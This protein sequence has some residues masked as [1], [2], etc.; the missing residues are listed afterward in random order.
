MN[1]V[2]KIDVKI[3][4]EIVKH[5]LI[6]PTLE[7]GGYLFGKYNSNYDNQTIDINGIYYEKIF[8]SK[9]RF[10]FSPSYKY[11]A[12]C[13]GNNIGRDFIGCYHSHG[14]YPAIF[15]DVDRKMEL[16]YASN[17]TALIY[18]PSE[19]KIVGDIITYSNIY[20]ARISVI[21]PSNNNR[22]YY[23]TLVNN[24]GKILSIKDVKK[25]K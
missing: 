15:S 14:E 5:A 18:S 12:L 3:L 19:N 11:R 23:P 6:N 21:N 9:K 20:E 10:V 24:P 8:G 7:C 17:K 25:S 16:Y 2:I 1:S 4:D 13:F 22:L